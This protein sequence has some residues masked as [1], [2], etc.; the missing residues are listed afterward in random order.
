M[1]SLDPSP[2]GKHHT[3]Q[4]AA[5]PFT[6]G[7][8][9]SCIPTGEPALISKMEAP[10]THSDKN[11]TVLD[12]RHWKIPDIQKSAA[13]IFVDEDLKKKQKKYLFNSCFG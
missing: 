1:I 9:S 10:G 6:E 3:S 13:T 5:E 7:H 11:R 8:V 12:S 4:E 2:P